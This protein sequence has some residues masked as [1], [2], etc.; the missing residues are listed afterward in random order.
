MCHAPGAVQNPGLTVIWKTKSFLLKRVQ[1]I[2]GKW[3]RLMEGNKLFIYSSH[4]RSVVPVPTASVSPGNLLKM[5]IIEPTPNL[6]NQKLWVGAQQSLFYQTL[7][8]TL[9]HVQVWGPLNYTII[10]CPRWVVWEDMWNGAKS[11]L[12]GQEMLLKEVI[13]KWRIEGS[14]GIGQGKVRWSGQKLSPRRA[15]TETG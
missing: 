4:S 6:L 9:M 13:S 15:R 14:V 5:H 7:C 12:W 11:V 2:G 3:R 1:F 8:L 10:R